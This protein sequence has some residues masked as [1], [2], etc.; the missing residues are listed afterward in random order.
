MLV[1]RPIHWFVA[2][3]KRLF[4]IVIAAGVL[5][6]TAPL[7]LLVALLVVLDSPG[8]VLFRQQRIGFN[9][10]PFSILK[11][12]TM[13]MDASD[14]EG[15]LGTQ[16][17]DPRVTR[18]GHV[19]RRFSI[20]ELPQLINVLVGSLS[21]V[22]P[23]PQATTMRIGDRRYADAV[24]QYI[25]RHKVKP[26]LTGLAQVSGSR[27]SIYT[28]ETAARAVSKDLEYI[29]NWSLWLDARIVWKTVDLVLS[30]RNGPLNTGHY[31]AAEALSA[32]GF[33]EFV[34]TP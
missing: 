7:L 16:Q 31:W 34:P 9:N 22:G 3:M 33:T 27:S 18:A 32:A 6:G 21:V 13:V 11:F 24:V 12:R 19:L 29:E 10:R 26:G 15:N 30:R 20:D 17:R 23:R 4:D 25:E 14:Q 5:I 28:L 2:T 8:G 1:E